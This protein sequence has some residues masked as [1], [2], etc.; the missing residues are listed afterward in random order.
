MDSKDC[1]KTQ[2]TLFN[3]FGFI[4]MNKNEL[5][6]YNTLY[7]PRFFQIKSFTTKTFVDVAK[8]DYVKKINSEDVKNLD[9]EDVKNL[10]LENVKN[11]DL[12]NVKN[13]DLENVKNLDLEE[14]SD[15]E[16]ELYDANMKSI[17]LDDELCKKSIGTQCDVEDIY[18]YV[19]WIFVK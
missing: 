8:Q 11:L 13:L 2:L 1:N 17:N 15:S 14:Y 6:K 19:E 10:D 18:D 5:F 16:D 3:K 4:G 7:Q 12:E 9:L